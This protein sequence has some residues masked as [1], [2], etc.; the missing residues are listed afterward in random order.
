MGG[1]SWKTLCIA[2]GILFSVNLSCAQDVAQ[3]SDKQIFDEKLPDAEADIMKMDAAELRAFTGALVDCRYT[4]L[5]A[6]LNFRIACSAARQKFRIEYGRGRAVDYV[7]M[8]M[9]VATERNL[10]TAA[11]KSSASGSKRQEDARR[12]IILDELNKATE[13]ANADRPPT[14]ISIVVGAEL[15]LQ[16]AAIESFKRKRQP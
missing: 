12:T 8:M 15:R 10:A 9:E 4:T 5:V 11:A 6:G 2:I 1:C 13:A 7:M 14:L 16:N 3:K